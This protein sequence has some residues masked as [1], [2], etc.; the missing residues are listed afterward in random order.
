MTEKEKRDAR[1]Y[2]LLPGER[3]IIAAY[4][5]GK[6]PITGQPLKPNANL[7]HCHNTG[8]LRGLL[9]PMTNKRLVDNMTTLKNTL[10]YLN[11]P[12]APK[13][14]GETVY[15]IL[16]RA[17]RK[18]RVRYGPNGSERPHPRSMALRPLSDLDVPQGQER[19]TD[20]RRASTK[21]RKHRVSTSVHPLFSNAPGAGA[22]AGDVLVNHS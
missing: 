10:A 20:S 6:D 22:E 4:Q 16:G 1:L 17:Q 2:N 9:N 12:P 11:D 5:G 15:G 8:K 14:L 19:Q 7:D 18:K 3:Q 13:A 21:I